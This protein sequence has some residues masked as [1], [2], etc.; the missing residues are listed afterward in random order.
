ME[1]SIS[2]A[3]RINECSYEGESLDEFTENVGHTP[4]ALNGLGGCRIWKK[5]DAC[6]K[7][8]H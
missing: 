8:T 5:N 6:S 7:N 1:R 4:K 2:L 3:V